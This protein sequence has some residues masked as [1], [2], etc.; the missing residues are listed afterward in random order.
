MLPS[1][2]YSEGGKGE[3]A[4][5][6]LPPWINEINGF[7]GI[8]GHQSVLSQEPP[9]SSPPYIEKNLSSLWKVRPWSSLN[10]QNNVIM[11]ILLTL[12]PCLSRARLSRSSTPRSINCAPNPLSRQTIFRIADAHAACTRLQIQY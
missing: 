1:V 7:M 2:A 9:P 11:L 8:F 5:L 3:Y 10:F 12:S 4:G 6:S